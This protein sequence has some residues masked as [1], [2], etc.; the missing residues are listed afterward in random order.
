MDKLDPLAGMG[1]S[2]DEAIA[3]DK[4]L[5]AQTRKGRKDRRVCLCGH[6]VVRH[7]E[8]AGV[9]SCK[10]TAMICPCKKIKPVLE[11][12]DIRPFLRKT[13]GS[14]ALHALTRGIASAVSTEH[15][16]TW[17]INLV[18]DRCAG[19]DGGVVPAA[20]TQGGRLSSSATGYDALLCGKCR[21][22]M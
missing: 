6:P 13:E 5:V 12:D 21:T 3:V 7:N 17:L 4:K 1:I 20:V 15:K 2:L 22:E 19:T 8:Y 18:C 16:V 9:L 14:G 10:P 11:S